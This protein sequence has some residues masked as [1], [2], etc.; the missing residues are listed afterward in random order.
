MYRG[1][2]GEKMFISVEYGAFVFF[3]RIQA[4]AF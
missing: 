2:F 4:G 3:L 1:Y